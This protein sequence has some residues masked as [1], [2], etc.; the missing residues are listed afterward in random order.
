M[1]RLLAAAIILT[2]CSTSRGAG[3]DAGEALVEILFL[4]NSYTSVNDLPG[5]VEELATAAGRPL[6]QESI[7]PGGMT[8]DGHASDSGTV[9]K[10]ASRR[11]SYVVLQEQSLMPILEPETFFASARVL[12]GAVRAAGSRTLFY[13]TWP[14][15]D[16]PENQAKL[17]AAYSQIARELSA[18]V[19]PV[20]P[21]WAAALAERPDLALYSSDGSHPGPQGTYLAALV[22]FAKIFR[23]SPEGLP[24]RLEHGGTVL[25]DLSGDPALAGAL[26]RIAW[27][28]VQS[29]NP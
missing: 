9:A 24:A 23:R 4:G 27:R 5:M 3:P 10:I 12:D 13:L 15:L 18:D 29:F 26:Q 6:R 19:A 11:W 20:G 25:V 7:T 28:T 1:R 2:G 17:T 14:R 16:A 22:F 8:L 21:A